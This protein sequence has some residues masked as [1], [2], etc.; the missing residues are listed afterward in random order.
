[1]ETY[2]D[3]DITEDTSGVEGAVLPEK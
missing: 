1:M 3:E 2:R